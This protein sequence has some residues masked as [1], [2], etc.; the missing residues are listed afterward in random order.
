[1]SMKTSQQQALRT[2]AGYSRCRGERDKHESSEG[3]SQ[4]QR[5]GEERKEKDRRALARRHT[6][7]LRRT[8]QLCGRTWLM[9]FKAAPRSSGRSRACTTGVPLSSRK[10]F[11]RTFWAIP[12]WSDHAHDGGQGSL[13]LRRGYPSAA[14][15]SWWVTAR[16]WRRMVG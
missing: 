11:S 7:A 2:G 6:R 14:C 4:H 5:K 8:A 13:G 10:G 12:R 15:R 16:I 9:P 1:M 3:C